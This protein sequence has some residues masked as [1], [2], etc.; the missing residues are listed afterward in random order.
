MHGEP[1]EEPLDRREIAASGETRWLL[2]LFL[3][4]ATH[5][6]EHKSS[7]YQTISALL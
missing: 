1:L 4:D 6:E 3:I 5:D 2:R 7:R